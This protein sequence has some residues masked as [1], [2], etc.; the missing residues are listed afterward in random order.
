MSRGRF[1]F[2]V[3]ITG[4]LA[5]IAC[6]ALALIALSGFALWVYRLLVNSARLCAI[7]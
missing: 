2:T 3:G 7:W 4:R 6:F 5:P 1:K